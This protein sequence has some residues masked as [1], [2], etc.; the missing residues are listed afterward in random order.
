MGYLQGVM[1]PR[2]RKGTYKSILVERYSRWAGQFQ[3]NVKQAV[4]L[5][6]STRKAKRFFRTLFDSTLCSASAISSILKRLD[7]QVASFHKRPL[8][9]EFVYLFLDGFAVRIKQA[10]R[11]PY[12]ALV[13]WE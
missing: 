1:V 8:A 2:S 9:D 12:T 10:L 6:L 5:G 4:L 13:A 11:R 7:S 3:E